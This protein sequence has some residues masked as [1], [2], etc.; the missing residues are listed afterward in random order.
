[1]RIREPMPD[2]HKECEMPKLLAIM[3]LLTF[4]Q[5]LSSCA[6][7]GPDVKPAVCPKPQPVSESLM[8]PSNAAEKVR[9]ELFEPQSSAMP[10]SPDSKK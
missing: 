9:A 7:S 6:A 4:A 2:T 8:Q 10:K 5:M 1:M 3:S